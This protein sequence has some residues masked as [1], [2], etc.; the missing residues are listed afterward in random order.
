MLNG[1]TNKLHLNVN[2]INN[3]EL[4]QTGLHIKRTNLNTCNFYNLYSLKNDS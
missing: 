2:K 3:I 1:H 4:K